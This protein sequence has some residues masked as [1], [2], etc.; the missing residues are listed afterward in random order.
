MKVLIGTTNPSK[1]K[2]FKGLSYDCEIEF[3]TLNDL[4]ISDEPEEIGKT[5]EENAIIKAK[6]Y[7][8]CCDLVICNDS[9]LYFSKLDLNDKRQPG[10]HIRTPFGKRLDDSEM[11]EYYKGLISS[12]GGHVE[13]YYLDGIAVYNH[14]NVTSYMDEELAQKTSSFYMI[15]K[16]SPKR[17]PG[18]PL[19]SLSIYKD[20]DAYF[21]D[22]KEVESK[23]SIIKQE[24]QER[25]VSFLKN[26]LRI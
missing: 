23:D 9:G 2:R 26:A 12:L 22:K 17:H 3:L 19:D 25:I 6:F 18:W 15:D 7:G 21:V 5:P 16:A 14:G 11:I 24:Y 13:A 10:L 20:R 1:V 8:K 4:N